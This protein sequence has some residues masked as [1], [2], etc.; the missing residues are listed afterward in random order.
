MDDWELLSSAVARLAEVGP[1]EDV[2]EWVAAELFAIEPDALV[3]ASSR[4]PGSGASTARAI[5]GPPGLV[6]EARAFLGREVKGLTF[7]I[8]EEVRGRLAEGALVRLEGGLRQL[9]FDAI[10][11]ELGQAFERSLG[12]CAVFVQPFALK[13]DLRGTAALLSRAPELRQARVIEA[14]ARHAAVAIHRHCAESQLSENER[15]F[16]MLAENSQDVVFRLRLQPRL[17]V[18]YVSPAV[19]RI[20]DRA[21]EDLYEDPSLIRRFI[22]PEQAQFLESVLRAPPREPFVLRWR[23]EDGQCLC[24]ELRITPIAHDGGRVA[25]IEGIGRDVTARERAEEALR[26][27]DRRKDEFLAVLAHELRTLLAPMSNG[28]I[29]L[30]RAPPGGEQARR[31]VEIVQRQVSHMARIVEDLL[32]IARISRGKIRLVRERIELNHLVRHTA[33][34]HRPL[35]EQRGIALEVRLAGGELFIDGD[36]TRL[37]QVV[38]NLLQNAAKFTP[39]G[40]ATA[41]SVSAEPESKEAIL[42]VCDSGA[43]IAAE[44]LPHVFEPFVQSERT[45]KRS[46]GGV[47]LG[48]A[49]VKG[50]VE[51]HSGTVVASSEGPGRGAQFTVRLPRTGAP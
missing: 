11:A 10:P 38:A 21:P 44:L 15:R 16:R 40:G 43:G 3:V 45:R 33:E 36:R 9:A 31:A 5:A 34:D 2:F 4:D 19:A 46:E 6:A 7:A 13:G 23:R 32:D 51:M 27:A 24:T 50:L 1:D 12:I 18:E 48:L 47:G 20:L 22:D 49:L 35:F 17:A 26:E 42:R 28:L 30:D 8:D 25:V 41:L 29:V 37:T 14:Y 39:A